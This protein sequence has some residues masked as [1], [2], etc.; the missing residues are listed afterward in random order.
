MFSLD[1]H[2]ALAPNHYSGRVKPYSHLV[3]EEKQSAQDEVVV[4]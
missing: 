4:Q 3:L 1:R 2:G